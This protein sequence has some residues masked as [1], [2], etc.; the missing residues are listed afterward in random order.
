M[1]VATPSALAGPESLYV[2]ES[3]LEAKGFGPIAGAD[4]AGRGACAGPLVAAAVVLDGPLPGVTDSK[5]LSPQAR[6]RAFDLIHE[7]ARAV[8]VIVISPADVDHL[9]VQEANLTALRRAIARLSVRP[10]YV[11]TDGFAVPG[12][13]VES[14]AVWK[15]DRVSASI[16]AASVIAKVTRDRMM[17]ELDSQFPQYGFAKHKGY[18]TAAHTAALRT[19][20]PCQHHRLTYANVKAAQEVASR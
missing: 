11:L 20:G 14:L 10:G 4:E 9:G 1:R 15:G 18:V 8:E 7:S 2:Y 19:H 6:D 17:L 12:L 3:A 16:A 5:L 13:D